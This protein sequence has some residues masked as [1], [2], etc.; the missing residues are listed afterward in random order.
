MTFSVYELAR[1]TTYTADEWEHALNALGDRAD[2]LLATV[3]GVA[4]RQGFTPLAAVQAVL[5]A[6]PDGD[7]T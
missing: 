6:V 3:K 4:A 7:E 2:G 1:E 5:A